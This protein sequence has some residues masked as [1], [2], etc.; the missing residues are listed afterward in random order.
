MALLLAMV[1][2]G[3][4]Q[5]T[6]LF[7]K[8][9]LLVA[10]GTR[11]SFPLP[12]SLIVAGSDSVW[13]DGQPLQRAFDYQ[14]DYG[15]GVLY[16][17]TLPKQG[18]EIRLVYRRFP[19]ELPRTYQ[20]RPLIRLPADSAAPPPLQHPPP[21]PES[22]G[23]ELQK[24]GSI[25]RGITIGSNRGLKVDSGLRMQV[26]GKVSEN[27]EVV[28]SLT[29]QNTPIQPEGNTQTLQEIDKVFVEL[30]GRDVHVT[31]GDYYLELAGPEFAHYARK[32]QGAMATVR[33][34]PVSATAS[35]AVSR[36]QFRTQYFLGQE[37]YQGPY[38]LKGDRGQI[39][40]IVLAG[41]EKVWVDGELMV[42]GENNDY[43]IDYSSAQITFTRRRLITGD[44]RITV[45][46][47]YS[48][49]RFRRN[50]Y[51]FR[52][53]A[54][55]WADKVQV[56]FSYLREADDKD[57]PLDFTLT[58]QRLA[59]LRAAG[60]DPD[61]AFED[62][63]TYVGPG[64]GRYLRDSSGVFRYVGADSGAYNVSFSDV[65]EGKGDYAYTGAGV[66]RY[67]GPGAGRYAPVVLL[68]T[69]RSHDLFGADVSL[70]PH[71]AVRLSAE[72][73]ISRLDRNSYSPVGDDDNRG[74]A[75]SVSLQLKPEKLRL[76]GATLG[77][78]QLVAKVRRVDGRFADIDRTTVV[79]YERRWDLPDSLGREEVVQELQGQYLPFSGL[80]LRGEYGNIRKGSSFSARRFGF[81]SALARARLP[82]TVYRVEYI[83]RDQSS[84]N[85]SGTWLRQRG[86][87]DYQWWKLH[88]I[89]G[90]ENEIRRE[91]VAD[92]L[93]SGFRFDVYQAGVEVVGMGKM[94]GGVKFSY[95]DDRDVRAGAFVPKSVAVTQTYQWALQRWRSLSASAEFTHRERSYAD[96][97]LNDQ[98]T[99]LAE[100]K[101]TFSPW[102]RAL[103]SEWHYQVANTAVAKKERVY[104]KVSPGDGTY[105][106]DP[107]LNEYVPDPLGDYV[108]RTF[109]TEQFVPVVELRTSAKI[110][111]EPRLLLAPGPRQSTWKERALSALA[112]ETLVRI[113]E[114]SRESD[115]WQIYR[116]NLRRF[117][118]DG[119]TVA[120]LITL[121]QDLFVLQQSRLFS[122]RLRYQGRKEKNNQYLEGGQDQRL[123]EWSTRVTSQLGP[124]LGLQV[125]AAQERNTRTF[126][127][128]GRQNRDVRSRGATVAVSYRPKPALEL[129]LK[130]K[131]AAQEDVAFSPPTKALFVSLQPGAVYSLPGKGQMRADVEWVQVGVEPA[132]R[133]IPYEVAEGNQ[134]GATLRWNLAV[135]YRVSENVRASLSYS[136]RSEP[137]RPEALHVAKAEVRAFF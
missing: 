38:Q 68:P 44:S 107:Q 67:V 92:T 119:T 128:A 95:R 99:D 3:L 100:V 88:P 30:K 35:G 118:R 69:A 66:Y 2:L 103:S 131:G 125:D 31:M 1:Q 80:E 18:A 98:K 101:A 13:L 126:R 130:A 85:R 42:R 39:D 110:R 21:T 37:G 123:E 133:V 135:D 16:L 71:P 54:Q 124:R 122:L 136:G 97:Q 102:R 104:I 91:E 22:F 83:E 11:L 120:G 134:P 87:V 70:A 50:I 75:S 52:S 32:L 73:A 8:D 84:W 76:F 132:G 53:T 12:D 40:I 9:V 90:Y 74:L 48:D 29:D 61:K 78:G 111:L 56:G 86:T 49:E 27:L 33:R 4:A 106:F 115:P 46:F 129:A 41:T 58:E 79:E 34:G 62:G 51:A 114:K 15:P 96:P 63:A 112:S 117:Q 43:V 127:F 47:Q 89:V 82:R 64:K 93:N 7:E 23:A 25:V 55:P 6:T 24:S 113:E 26:S 19:Y 5:S 72:G 121:R 65:G 116:L 105:R 10:D 20:R 57:N 108:L 14:L 36:G 59:V 109:T 137:Q 60:D 77:S 17:R 45:D 81:Q 94:T 28:A